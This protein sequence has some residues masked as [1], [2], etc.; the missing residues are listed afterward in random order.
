MRAASTVPRGACRRPPASASAQWALLPVPS[1]AEAAAV[2][3]QRA[4]EGLRGACRR[5]PASAS[6]QWA[7]LPAPSLAEAAAAPSQLVVAAVAPF[8]S[9]AV[10]RTPGSWRGCSSRRAPPVFPCV[11]FLV[12]SDGGG[13]EQR[14]PQDHAFAR[15]L[16]FCVCCGQSLE[17]GLSPLG[18][19]VRAPPHKY[20][21]PT[22]TMALITSD[23]GATRLREH[24]TALITSDCAPSRPPATAGSATRSKFTRR[25]GSSV[26]RRVGL[27]LQ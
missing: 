27:Q 1:L 23:C 12:R 3:S 9:A 26:V 17:F 22:D 5:L 24:Q 2:P 11:V 20:G 7:L 21:L 16:T 14:T 25:Q 13:S 15:D 19:S 10:A 18:T 4:W 8:S 6:A